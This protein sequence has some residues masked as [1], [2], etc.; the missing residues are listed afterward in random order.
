M[1][2]PKTTATAS[3]ENKIM[4]EIIA[5]SPAADNTRCELVLIVQT[6]FLTLF[7][8]LENDENDWANTRRRVD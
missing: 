2:N 5:Q 1:I 7:S 6:T 3:F 4:P 8:G